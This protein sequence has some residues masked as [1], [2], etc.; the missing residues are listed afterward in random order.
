MQPIDF[1]APQQ[2]LRFQR[3]RLPVMQQGEFV[4]AVVAGVKSGSRDRAGSFY[5]LRYIGAEGRLNYI[6]TLWPIL[7]PT[8]CLPP[9]RCTTSDGSRASGPIWAT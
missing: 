8:A 1:R 2:T 9:P 5:W 4:W 7:Y 3:D 6:P